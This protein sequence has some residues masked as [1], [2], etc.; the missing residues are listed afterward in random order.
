MNQGKVLEVVGARVDLDFSGSEL[1]DILNAVEVERA[2][3][4]KLVLEI[5]QHLGENRL[6][7]I[8]M[9][10]TDGL[11]RGAV[12]TNTGQPITVPVGEGSLG[13]VMN[14]IGDPIDEAGPI[15]TE[16]RYSIHQHPPEH[17][18]L[19]TVAE[20]LETGI[21]VIDLI[22]PVA[23]GG[24]VGLFGGA[25]VGKTVLIAELINN[26]AT[27]HGGY[28]VFCGVG[29]RTRE[30]NGFWLELDEYG[31]L[32]KTALVFG[33][34]NEPP[35]ARLRVG[36]AGLAIA[37]YFRDEQNQDVLIFID[38]VFRF[39]MAGAEVSALMG[40]MPS[41]V[42]YQPT[43]A[44]EMGEMQERITSTEDGSITSF[45]AV[46]V[47]A[48]DY[49]D[50]AVITVFGHLDAATR[51]ER[52]IVE[53]GRYPA[54]DPLTSTSRIL[55][56]AVIGEEHYQTAR[57]VQVTLQEYEDLKDIIAILGVDELTD[58]QKIVVSRA[59]KIEMFLS[60][61]M[62][63]AARFTNTPG[64]YVKI[65]DTIKGCRMI[66]DG[67]CDDLSE[68]S[69]YMVGPIEEAFEKDEKSEQAA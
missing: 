13:R 29:E 63:V 40:R 16:K 57:A 56:P 35:G 3:G 7:C 18:K 2:D 4:S 58:E 41:A 65:E 21:K 6:R 11:V 32:D 42:G 60:Q 51:L 34:M 37:E 33:Q 49:T 44:T 46:Y 39:T 43:L 61:P 55:D 45:Q 47:P 53:K 12:A 10:T 31:V 62:F 54:V 38:N 15:E 36:L 30:G 52:S 8:S 48:D 25:G 20:M 66:L 64:K 5:Q 23:K 69:L 68:Q 28:S 19:S 59:R 26:I 17:T 67:E 50:P 24:K 22:Q 9:D 14:V 27:Q 1:P